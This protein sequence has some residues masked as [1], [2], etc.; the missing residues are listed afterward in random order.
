MQQNIANTTPYEGEEENLQVQEDCSRLEQN[1]SET[2][3]PAVSSNE[4]SPT[5][6]EEKVE[7]PTQEIIR[8]ADPQETCDESQEKNG[9]AAKRNNVS[10]KVD[11]QN[12]LSSVVN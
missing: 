7:K 3:V 2:E 4:S 11:V 12:A 10:Y 8:T 9:D 1:E 6:E 5:K